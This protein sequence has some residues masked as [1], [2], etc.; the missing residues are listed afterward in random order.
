MRTH[1]FERRACGIEQN[2]YGAWQTIARPDVMEPLV[3]NEQ[4]RAVSQ[5]TPLTMGLRCLNTANR[6]YPG[7]AACLGNA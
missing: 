7:A 3:E 1:A 6:N 2:A 4:D 5:K